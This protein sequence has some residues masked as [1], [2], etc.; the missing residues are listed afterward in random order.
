M[1]F[2][3]NSCVVQNA[4]DHSVMCVFSDDV[5]CDAFVHKAAGANIVPQ[6]IHEGFRH[7]RTLTADSPSDLDGSGAR[8]GAWAWSDTTEAQNRT[9]QS[10][11]GVAST[12]GK[13]R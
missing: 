9:D 13:P 6:V 5:D 8:F 10:V 4:R 1:H 11:A 2:L 3:L 12:G 7:T